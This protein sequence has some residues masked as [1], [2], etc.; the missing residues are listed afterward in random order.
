MKQEILE[1]EQKLLRILNYAIQS[2][3]KEAL[4]YLLNYYEF[5]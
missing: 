4:I 2:K 5:F 1:T 3:K